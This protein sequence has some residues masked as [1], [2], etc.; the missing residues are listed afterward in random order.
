M[1]ISK[2]GAEN[3]NRLI[4]KG[5]EILEQNNY[6]IISQLY[7]EWKNELLTYFKDNGFSKEQQNEL[8]V[9]LHLL[10]DEYS[11][12]DSIK[13]IKDNTKEVMMF[14][15]SFQ[16]TSDNMFSQDT[17]KKIIE[18]IL[19]NVSLFL[20]SMYYDEPHKKCTFSSELLHQITIGN[21][22]DVQHILYSLL[23]TVFPE[24]R[25]EVNGDNGYSGIRS[26][27]YLDKYDITIEVK[28]T[29][30]NMTE[31]QLTEELG[32]DAFHYKTQNLYLF[33]CD[34]EDIIKNPEAYKM[35][36]LRNCEKD[37]KN[38]QMVIMHPLVV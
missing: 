22:Y 7:V 29:R 11:Q 25:K 10:I 1:E 9:K 28:C 19:S 37:G 33:I 36:F 16:M 35:A 14:L 3:E 8:K 13:H 21:E 30:K 18:H 31:K 4:R 34:K 20:K 6:E 23:R 15:G 24:I 2:T 5:Y 32:S 17:V 38:V 12:A 27:L 26:D